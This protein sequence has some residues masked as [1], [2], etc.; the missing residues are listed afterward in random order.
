M[1]RVEVYGRVLHTIDEASILFAVF[2]CRIPV[3]VI[4]KYTIL[5]G[6]KFL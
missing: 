3:S 5:A 1:A 6:S 4:L 2:P